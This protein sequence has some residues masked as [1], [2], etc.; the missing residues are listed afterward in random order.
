MCSNKRL[1][2][3]GLSLKPGSSESL[4]GAVI[5]ELHCSWHR[6]A[7]SKHVMAAL[8]LLDADNY[9]R[10]LF[11]KSQISVNYV[12]NKILSHSTAGAK[13]SVF[14]HHRRLK[15]FCWM[16]LVFFSF[17]VRLLFFYFLFADFLAVFS[18]SMV[19]SNH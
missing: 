13:L 1:S 15:L 17:R 19:N 9:N 2:W 10:I 12:E 6:R 5:C 18:N 3:G 4:E 16:N 8:M 14:C 11:F 7:N